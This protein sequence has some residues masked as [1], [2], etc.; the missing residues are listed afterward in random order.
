LKIIWVWT[1]T[2]DPELLFKINEAIKK[3]GLDN[4][5]FQFITS[6]GYMSNWLKEKFN[7]IE[8]NLKIE[9]SDFPKMR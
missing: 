7:V 4:T 3:T 9:E 5:K 6:S 8:V 1:V 2:D